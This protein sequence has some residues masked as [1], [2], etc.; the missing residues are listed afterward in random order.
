MKLP[1]FLRRR[2]TSEDREGLVDTPAHSDTVENDDILSRENGPRP[3][4]RFRRLQRRE[5]AEK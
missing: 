1:S 2:A 3:T 4:E 5:S